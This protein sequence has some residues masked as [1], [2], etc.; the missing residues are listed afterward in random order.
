MLMSLKI[1]WIV[2]K[3]KALSELI[4]FFLYRSLEEMLDGVNMTI[5]ID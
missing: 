4:S 2:K 3:I 1:K 5:A